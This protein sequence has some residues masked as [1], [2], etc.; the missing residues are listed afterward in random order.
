MEVALQFGPNWVI[1]SHD[2]ASP[3]R[4][5][6]PF[7]PSNLH[8]GPQGFKFPISGEYPYGREWDP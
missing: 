4:W 7:E 2:V 6:I 5:R 1:F 8:T 3:L